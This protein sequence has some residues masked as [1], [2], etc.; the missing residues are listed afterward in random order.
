MKDISPIKYDKY[1]DAW[2]RI[3]DTTKIVKSPDFVNPLTDLTQEE[4]DNPGLRELRVMSDPQYLSLAAKVFLGINLLPEQSVIL[5]ELWTKQFPMFIASRGWGKSFLLAVYAM[6][7]LILTPCNEDGS[8]GCKIIIVGAAFRQSKIIFEYMENLWY[9]SPIYRSVS[10]N[11][12]HTGPNHDTDRWSMHVN[13]NYAIAIPLGD[14]CL[15]EGTFI[16]SSEGFTTIE[17]KVNSIW[18][19]G[20]FRDSDEHYNNGVRDVKK[21]TTN[22]GFSFIGTENHHMKI[23]RNGEIEWVSAD[24][25][26]VG[27]RILIDRSYRWHD[28][29][30]NCSESDAY[31]LGVMIGDGSW[32]NKYKLRFTTEDADHFLPTLNSSF[33]KQFSPNIDGVHWDLN[34]ISEVN[35]WVDYW[36]LEH[37]CY[38]LDK[39]LPP[40]ILRAPRASMTACLQGLFDTDGTLQVSIAKGGTSISISFT[41][42]S[43]KLVEQIQYI[44]LHYGIISNVSYRDRNENWHTSY[45]LLMTG[46]DAVKFAREIGFR[47]PRKNNI[48]QK[49]INQKIR[50]TVIDDTIPDVK[51][52]M[53]KIAKNNKSYLYP[54]VCASKIAARK[55]ITFE[56]AK[57]FLEKFGH[58]PDKFISKLKELVYSNAFY[59]EI[60][61]IED[62]GKQ[63]TYD[64]HVPNG[65]EYCANGFF[66]HNSKIRGLRATIIIADEFA[67]ISPAIY[68]TVVGG[69]A[70]TKSAPFEGV[71]EY[72]K[73]SAMMEDGVWSDLQEDIYSSKLGNQSIISGT[74][75][76]GFKHFAQYW[77]KHSAYI[78]N[79]DNIEELKKSL[80]DTFDEEEALGLN[81]KSYSIIRLPYELVPKGFMDEKVILRA[82]A[83]V[84]TSIYNMEYGAV[85]VD[86]SDG[87]FKR[88]LIESCVANEANIRGPH[89]APWC[90]ASFDAVRRGTPGMGYVYG[91]DPASEKDN[92]SI[93]VLEVH[94]NHQRVVYCWTTK[95]SD[96]IDRKNAGLIDTTD[97]NSY[98]ARKIRDLMK[99]FPLAEGHPMNAAIGMDAGG[100]GITVMES[101]HDRDK[102]KY[103]E[104]EQPIWP[105]IDPEKEGEYDLEAGLHILEMVQFSRA[106]WTYYANTGMRKDLED[107]ALLFPR[108]DPLSLEIAFTEDSVRV[109][110]YKKKFGKEL[111]LYDTLE[112]CVL[113]IEEL[114]NELTSIV[115]TRTGTGVGGRDRWDTPE[116]K[117]E[118]GKKG[119]LRKDRYCALLIAN[120]IARSIAR[121]PVSIEYD[122]IGG[123]TKDIVGGA[124]DEFTQ[125]YRGP[126]WFTEGSSQ[127][128]VGTAVRR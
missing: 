59:D 76:Y 10:G 72:Y 55:N 111:K 107:K 117:M 18:G 50:T 46:Q 60:V 52:N 79:H 110:E 88:S 87:Y 124:S 106:E 53:L 93:V 37:R 8:P 61:S 9:N 56:Y 103:S 64:M 41:N 66:S 14:G 20:V 17:N 29:N 47:L 115:H 127:G 7:R 89:W 74:A 128:F 12:Q 118:G 5:E 108:F 51:V 82:K 35:N 13:N 104:R 19:N 95:R 120:S 122:V 54:S 125:M 69:F 67:S 98:C 32:T 4:K 31:V 78:K 113:E 21:I 58:L 23:V 33:N 84:N 96:F 116:V 34:S 85:F 30:F 43:K 73:R 80:G 15:S 101:L 119:Y 2:L 48:L 38:T 40:N 105:I 91:V 28:G 102:I 109:E 57:L 62:A 27:D 65:H 39:E 123:F 75:D 68:E 90:P 63:Q 70:T 83:T 36:G 99:V 81:P 112:D 45:E 11:G 100:G 126:A 97:F 24:E 86:D 6:L 121:A 77:K 1:E 92:F 22:K 94:P 42:T 25:M 114:K 71:Q 49:A 44:L 26:V 16:T 3:G